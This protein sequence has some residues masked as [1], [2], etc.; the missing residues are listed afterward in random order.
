[1]APPPPLI[2]HAHSTGP[3][4]YK[5]A[6]A[7]ELLSIPYQVKK[8]DFSDSASGVK[9]PDFLS[10]NENGRVPALE[11]PQ[12]GVVSWES[13][14]VM[15]YLRRRYDTENKLGPKGKDGGEPTEQERVDAEKWE[16]L[17]VSTVGPMI[18][19]TNWF[20]H[21]NTTKNEDALRRYE[22]QSYRC[23]GV[24]EG[25]LKKTGG[26]SFLP[27]GISYVDLHYEPW[28]RQYEFAGL[29]L[30]EYPNLKKWLGKMKELEVVKRAY[31]KVADA[32][33][34]GA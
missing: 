14:A 24:I 2:L 33:E 31:K 6:I 17:L 25:Q 1:M 28:I 11:D 18:G 20:R 16:Y 29:S 32:P 27:G 13:G 30:D 22:A 9:G 21:Y 34:P 26:E 4:P 3:N 7:L 12:T 19:Q 15:N 10:I 5:I 23:F 8:W